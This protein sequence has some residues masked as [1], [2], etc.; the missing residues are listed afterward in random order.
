M[1]FWYLI[2]CQVSILAFAILAGVFLAFSDFIM[3]ALGA[4]PGGAE[5]MQ[6]INRAVFRYV[7]M[8]LF[9]GM[10]PV[11]LLIAVYGATNLSMPGAVLTALAGAVYLLAGFGVTVVFNVPMNQ[12]LAGMDTTSPEAQAYWADAYL[13]R[14]TAWNSVRAVACAVASGLMLVGMTWSIRAAVA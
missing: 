11:S 13:P 3:R 4:V 7:F 2:L 14:W 10:A 12:A 5:A 6:S 1:P 8:A 9:L